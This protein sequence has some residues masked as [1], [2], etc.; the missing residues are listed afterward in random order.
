MDEGELF[1]GRAYPRNEGAYRSRWKLKEDD[2][3]D[4]WL[5]SRVFGLGDN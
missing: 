4:K 1:A 2:E 5:G 3:M